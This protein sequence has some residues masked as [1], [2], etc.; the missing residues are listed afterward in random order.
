MSVRSYH[1]SHNTVH[2]VP[3]ERM[4]SPAMLQ[5]TNHCDGQPIY[6]ANLFSDC[7]NIQQ[8]LS[9]MLTN[10]ISCIDQRLAA[11][12]CCPLQHKRCCTVLCKT[13]FKQCNMKPQQTLYPPPTLTLNSPAFCPH[14]I[15]VFHVILTVNG[16]NFH[17]S[18]IQLVGL[19]NSDS[20]CSQ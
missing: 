11:I 12:V 6:S 2:T 13:Y 7:E 15:L 4:N 5:I 8:C 10:A 18:V 16:A 14:S 19:L 9:G 17:N 1:R 20:L 3:G